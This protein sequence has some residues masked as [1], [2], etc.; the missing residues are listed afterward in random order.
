MSM[1]DESLDNAVTVLPE[2]LLP[3][4][5][6]MVA[7]RR[8]EQ[9]PADKLDMILPTHSVNPKNSGSI[10]KLFQFLSELTDIEGNLESLLI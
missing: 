2:L 5:L 6:S 8:P 10:T 9:I 4:S 7:N 1:G 3:M